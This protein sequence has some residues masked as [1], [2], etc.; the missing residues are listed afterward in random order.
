MYTRRRRVQYMYS[1]GARTIR[2]VHVFDGYTYSTGTRSGAI[3]TSRV[4]VPRPR[5]QTG[6]LSADLVRG[7]TSTINLTPPTI[8]QKHFWTTLRVTVAARV[9][10]GPLGDGYPGHTSGKVLSTDV[11]WEYYKIRAQL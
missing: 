8:R 4:R 7:N 1:T 10:S 11:V 2:R 3:W 5:Q 9:R 6:S